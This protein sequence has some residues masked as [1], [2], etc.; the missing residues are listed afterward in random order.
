MVSSSHADVGDDP[1]PNEFIITKDSI[2]I[3]IIG[4]ENLKKIGVVLIK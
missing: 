4:M 3:I 2:F 1:I